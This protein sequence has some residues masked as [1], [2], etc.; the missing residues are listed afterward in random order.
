MAAD[1]GLI[2]SVSDAYKYQNPNFGKE[3]SQPI[4]E[5]EDR[6]RLQKEKLR[7]EQKVSEERGQKE[8]G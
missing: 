8:T 4:L 5:G 1:V 3:L 7:L 2:K 6:R